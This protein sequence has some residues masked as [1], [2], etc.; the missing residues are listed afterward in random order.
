MA[1]KQKKELITR[2]KFIK[3]RVTPAER[4]RFKQLASERGVTLSKLVTDL[5]EEQHK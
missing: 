2:D 4:E 5:L 3:I 1:I